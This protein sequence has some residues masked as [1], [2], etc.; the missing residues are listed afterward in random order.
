M[1][2]EAVSDF[3]DRAEV[4]WEVIEDLLAEGKLIETTF[5]RHTFYMR[6]LHDMH[7]NL[8]EA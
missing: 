1:R 7:N 4:D 5:D 2:R 3:L 6:K 8:E